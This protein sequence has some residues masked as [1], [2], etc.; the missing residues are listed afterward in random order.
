MKRKILPKIKKILQMARKN[1]QKSDETVSDTPDTLFDFMLG[2]ESQNFLLVYG[3]Q[4]RSDDFL[5]V[6]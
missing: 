3:I 5:Y 6:E 4:E 1:S 2:N